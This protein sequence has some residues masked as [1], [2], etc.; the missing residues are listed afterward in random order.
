MNDR[1]GPR[2]DG[3]V[4]I[5]TALPGHHDRGGSLAGIRGIAATEYRLAIRNRWALALA[6]VFGVFGLGLLTFSGASVGP[7]G[8]A[9]TIAS[10][11]VLAVYLVPLAA[12]AFGY[13]MIVGA[14]RDG[15]LAALFALPIERWRIAVATYLGRA[16][17][18]TAAISIGFGIPGIVLLAEM[19]IIGWEGYVVFLLA[20]IGLGL[21]FLAIAL[22]VSSLVSEKTHALGGALAAW[23]WFVLIHDLLALGIFAAIR[24]PDAVLAGVILSNPAGIFRVLVLGSLGASGEAGFASV[25]AA[26]GLST[27][28]LIGG[29]LAWIIGPVVLAGWLVRRRRF[30]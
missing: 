19:G 17:A 15:W 9:R 2:P 11:A 3:G 7:E 22:V 25:M 21:A 16:V 29:L 1:S 18:L 8:Y 20:A 23:V 27:P 28:V 10:L 12:L 6:A 4:T 13:D 14:H 24:L 26:A 30:A 5:G